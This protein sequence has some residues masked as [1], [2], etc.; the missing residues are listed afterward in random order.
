MWHQTWVDTDGTL[1]VLEGKLR[2]GKLVLQGQTTNTNAAPTKQRITWTPNPDGS[3]PQ[4]WEST[5]A[6]GKWIVAF[7]GTYTHKAS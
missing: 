4:L 1:L 5:D 6:T 7:D 2:D 3:V